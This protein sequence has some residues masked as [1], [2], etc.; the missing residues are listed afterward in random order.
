MDAA[1]RAPR[2]APHRSGSRESIAALAAAI[3]L[4]RVGHVVVHERRG[5]L[6]P[7]LDGGVR[8]LRRMTAFLDAHGDEGARRRRHRRAGAASAPDITSRTAS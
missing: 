1:G 7:H 6:W 3:T 4:N 2:R 8:A 5:G